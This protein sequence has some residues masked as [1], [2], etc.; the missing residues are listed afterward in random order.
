MI[1]FWESWWVCWH[2]D[3]SQVWSLRKRNNWE[4]SIS[5]CTIPRAHRGR[6]SGLSS[7]IFKESFWTQ[8]AKTTFSLSSSFWPEYDTLNWIISWRVWLQGGILNCKYMFRI[9]FGIRTSDFG[10]PFINWISFLWR[11]DLE[12]TIVLLCLI[13][14]ADSNRTRTNAL[15]SI[16][17]PL[18][19]P[20][21]TVAVQF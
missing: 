5:N 14:E 21:T 12:Q 17:I 20:A 8:K 2:T 18:R 1:I 6:T 4:D 11:S 7:R 15:L 10:T 9:V 16:Q 13:M 19:T 3:W